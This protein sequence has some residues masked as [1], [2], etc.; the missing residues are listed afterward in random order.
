MNLSQKQ[1]ILNTIESFEKADFETAFARRYKD[2]ATIDSILAAD[3][4]V[5]ELFA[6]ARKSVEQLKN[7]LNADDWQVLPLTQ[8]LNEYGNANIN[9]IVT[10]ITNRLNSCNYNDAAISIKALVYFEMLNGFWNMPKRLDLGV[11]ENT[12]SK[13]EQRTAL[14]ISHAEERQ[15]RINDLIEEIEKIKE[16]LEAFKAEKIT[17]FTTLEHNQSESKILLSDI[18]NLKNPSRQYIFHN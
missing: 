16:S 10:N 6:L 18:K 3:Y 11:R 1:N 5:A 7:R 8:N 9:N 13:L 2:T 15:K 17:E 14:L 12:L 4:S